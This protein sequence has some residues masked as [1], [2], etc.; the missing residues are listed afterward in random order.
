MSDRA[1][2]RL[3]LLPVGLGGAHP[4]QLL[5]PATIEIARSL[6][7]F[8]AENARSARRF[9]KDI[10]HPVPL[11]ELSVHELDAH[12]GEPGIEAA[13]AP[14]REGRDCGL[15]SEAG[16]P[17]VADP[18]AQLVLRAHAAGARVV[19]LV[20]PSAVLLALMGSG[21]DGQHFAFHGYLPVQPAQRA[22][23]LK[24]LE[25]RAHEATQFFIETPYRAPALLSAILKTCRGDTW[26]GIAAELTHPEE[27]VATRRVAEWRK[28]GRPDLDRRRAVF[29]LWR[30]RR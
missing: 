9:L 7:L 28:A 4:A 5:P 20:G 24:A 27:I 3:Y 21:M 8:V 17:A 30:E 11:R 15:L 16:C 10:A 18:G 6:R 23:R 26:L 25:A 22:A 14:L 1:G 19:P 2:G 29:L 13:L 12:A